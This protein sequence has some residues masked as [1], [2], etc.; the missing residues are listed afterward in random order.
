M[1]LDHMHGH[2]DTCGRCAQQDGANGS[3]IRAVAARQIRS[4]GWTAAGGR[5]GCPDHP[6]T[7]NR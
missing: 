5:V 1:D 7:T 6:V 2:C 3:R 4:A